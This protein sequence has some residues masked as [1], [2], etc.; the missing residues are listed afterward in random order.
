MLA[1]GINRIDASS[2]KIFVIKG[3]KD[4]VV[5]SYDRRQR[6]CPEP[7]LKSRWP[8]LVLWLLTSGHLTIPSGGF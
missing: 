7:W 8:F 2:P 3:I 6:F 5:W 4:T 1:V